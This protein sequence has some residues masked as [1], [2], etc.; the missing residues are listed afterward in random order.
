MLRE[1]YI[2][3]QLGGRVGIEREFK[4][5]RSNTGIRAHSERVMG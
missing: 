4:D 3:D 5:F 1:P 2:V